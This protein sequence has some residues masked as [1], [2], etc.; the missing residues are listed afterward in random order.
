[1][2]EETSVKQKQCDRVLEYIKIHGSITSLEAI[3]QIG[4]ARLASRICDLKKA[5]WNIE[6]KNET[7]EKKYGEKTRY[8][9]YTIAERTEESDIH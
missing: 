8:A 9:R 2:N 3:E 1:M 6:K 4:V 7:G 5:G